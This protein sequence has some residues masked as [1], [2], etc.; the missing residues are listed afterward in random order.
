M[1]LFNGNITAEDMHQVF[2]IFEKMIER[3][4]RYGTLVNAHRMGRTAARRSGSSRPG[5]LQDRGRGAG[6]DHRAQQAAAAQD[7]GV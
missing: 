3:Q 7:A 2:A 5:V 6:L 4:G 1:L